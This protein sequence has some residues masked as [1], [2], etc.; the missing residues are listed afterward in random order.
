[1]LAEYVMVTVRGAAPRVFAVTDMVASVAVSAGAPDRTTDVPDD[2][3][4]IPGGTFEV[5]V[6]GV[7]A[8][9]VKVIVIGGMVSPTV[10]CVEGTLD[11]AVI[12]FDA[13]F[14]V[15]G[16]EPERP[17]KVVAVTTVL[18]VAEIVVGVPEISPVTEM[19]MP[20]GRPVALYT[21]MVAFDGY[22][23]SAVTWRDAGIL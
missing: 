2:S 18:F 13:T 23:V 3:P 11:V 1:M 17:S 12:A 14:R 19:L 8:S 22:S 16:N 10:Y 20:S 21:P 4:A 7:P 6:M 5:N 9:D 15:S